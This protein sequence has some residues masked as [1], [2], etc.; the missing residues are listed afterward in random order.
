MVTWYWFEVMPESTHISISWASVFH[1]IY[2]FLSCEISADCYAKQFCVSVWLGRQL[3]VLMRSASITVFPLIETHGG[4]RMFQIRQ[5]CVVRRYHTVSWKYML[6][7]SPR[8]DKWVLLEFGRVWAFPVS[9][10][11]SLAS[12]WDSSA[13]G[14]FKTTASL[15][16]FSFDVLQYLSG[17]WFI[18]NLMTSS[19]SL[20]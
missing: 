7:C 20:T 19:I 14:A 5:W 11:S 15:P 17:L 1:I 12:L 9:G 2:F 4:S 18:K 16:G 8:Q 6:G 3:L 10:C 13:K